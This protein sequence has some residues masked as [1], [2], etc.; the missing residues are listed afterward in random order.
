MIS[1]IRRPTS[2]AI[3]LAMAAAKDLNKQEEVDHTRWVAR[4]VADRVEHT[5]LGTKREKST[6][7]NGM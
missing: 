5:K 1:S 2:M 6:R 3:A 7:I 4:A